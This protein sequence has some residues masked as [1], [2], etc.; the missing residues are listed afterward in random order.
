MIHLW[1]I[2]VHKYLQNCSFYSPHPIMSSL[3]VL[4]KFLGYP[5]IQL[6]KNYDFF[7]DLLHFVPTDIDQNYNIRNHRSTWAQI[8]KM[9]K[10]VLFVYRYCSSCT[11]RW[12][13]Q[14]RT[15]L[16]LQWK[17]NWFECSPITN[18]WRAVGCSYYATQ[19]WV[20]A[21]RSHRRGQKWISRS[22][23]LYVTL[24]Y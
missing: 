15:C 6:K 5:S 7:K 9:L 3:Y 23:A 21:E 24:D 16:Y 13:G 10:I 19:L 11:V 14:E 1:V 20:L 4:A 8:F 2:E 22:L 17:S 12:R 18:S